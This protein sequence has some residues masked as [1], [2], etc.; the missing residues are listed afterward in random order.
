MVGTLLEPLEW[1]HLLQ[2]VDPAETHFRRPANHRAGD[3][4]V[5]PGRV[6]IAQREVGVE[7]IADCQQAGNEQATQEVALVFGR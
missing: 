1:R 4:L 3:L 2:V 7:Q 5:Q 6:D